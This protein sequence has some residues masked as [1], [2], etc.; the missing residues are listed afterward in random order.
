MALLNYSDL[1]LSRSK[2]VK[3]FKWNN[4][5]IEVIQYL[6]ID[7]KYDIVM[8]TL[9]KSFENGIYNSIKLD[10]YFHLNLIYMF[11][12]LVFT[13]EER[14]DEPKLYD[15]MKSTGFLDK[16]LTVINPDEYKEMEEEI[17]YLSQLLMGYNTSTASIVKNFIEDLPTNAEA[18][19]KIIEN[20]DSEKYQNVVD[21]AKSANGDR[22]IPSK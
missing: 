22:D 20:F 15:E 12:N 21:F 10:M 6:P 4:Q 8:I 13:D 11:T 9:Q 16:F 18:A 7:D 2:G 1:K 17:D 14:L 3:T 5:D 19:A